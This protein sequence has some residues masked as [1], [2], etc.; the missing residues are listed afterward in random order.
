[1]SETEDKIAELKIKRQAA[2]DNLKASS[3]SLFRARRLVDSLQTRYNND[4]KE[5]EDLDR[6]LA[7]LDGR[8]KVEEPAWKR[9]TPKPASEQQTIDDMSLEQLETLA[10]RLGIKLN[11]KTP[12][13]GTPEAQEDSKDVGNLEVFQDDEYLEDEEEDAK[14]LDEFPD[15]GGD[16]ID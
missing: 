10:A 6:Q 5:W 8:F 9:K 7:M 2:Y 11:D 3:K 12:E 13:V 4:K 15:E 14:A 16:E 1:M